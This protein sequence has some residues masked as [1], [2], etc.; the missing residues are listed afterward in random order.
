MSDKDM[1]KFLMPDGTEV[2]NDPRFGLE[3]ALQKQLESEPYRGDAGVPDDEQAAQTQVTHVASM[4]SGQPGVGENA[5]PEDPTKD[6]HGPLGSPAQQRQTEDVQKAKEA[7]ASPRSTSVEDPE[8]VDSNKAVLEARKAKEERM[9]KAMKA[10]SKLGD[11]G[12]G[13]P[14]QPYSEWSS[15][16]LKAEALRRNAERDEGDLI[17]LEG[18]SKKSQLAERLE[19]DDQ[20][21][22]GSAPQG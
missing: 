2:S 7:G 4:N 17:D 3:E 12:P 11:E 21:Q 8:P 14:N 5:V 22:Q 13:D 18:I 10:E 16:Q 19:Q 1:V 9:K 20:R 6:L 15:A